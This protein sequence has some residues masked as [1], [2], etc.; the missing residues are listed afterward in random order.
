[1]KFLTIAL[2]K[3]RK[4]G[5]GGLVRTGFSSPAECSP[6]R[7]SDRWLNCCIQGK[8]LI[9][10]IAVDLPHHPDVTPPYGVHSP[11]FAHIASTFAL[12]AASISIIAGHGRSKPSAFHLRVASMPI[13][14]P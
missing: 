8:A 4:A 11:S 14:E 10:R 12:V 13:F 9:D 6:F 1:L 2:R 3:I 5:G 7:P